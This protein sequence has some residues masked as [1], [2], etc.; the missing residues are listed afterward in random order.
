MARQLRVLLFTMYKRDYELNQIMEKLK[1][2]KFDHEDKP[3]KTMLFD[4][5]IPERILLT[6]C[7]PELEERALDNENLWKML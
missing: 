2:W 6:K 5:V 3:F 4:L 7:I 1:I